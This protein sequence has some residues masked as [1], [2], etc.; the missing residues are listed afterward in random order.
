MSLDARP[1]LTSTSDLVELR[2]ALWRSL[3]ERS[4][5]HY[6]RFPAEKE[7]FEAVLV[8]RAAMDPEYALNL[9]SDLSLGSKGYSRLQA[10]LHPHGPCTGE[11][12]VPGEVGYS[13]SR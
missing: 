8:Q 2:R 1:K 4:I 7:I 9:F 5:A 11:A 10:A 12:V 3:D 13:V 6:Q